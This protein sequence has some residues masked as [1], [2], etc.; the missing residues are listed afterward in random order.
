MDKQGGAGI[1]ILVAEDDEDNRFI[2]KMLLEM[3]GYRV[4]TAINGYDAV[5]QAENKRPD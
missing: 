3:R 4:V 2:M 1:T 5:T